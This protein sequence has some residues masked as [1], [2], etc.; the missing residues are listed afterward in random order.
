MGPRDQGTTRILSALADGQ[1]WLMPQN[2]VYPPVAA[3]KA[4]ILGKVAAVLRRL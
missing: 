3:E 1:V 2:P 4:A